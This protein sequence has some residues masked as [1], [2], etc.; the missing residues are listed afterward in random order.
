MVLFIKQLGIQFHLING[1][2]N[3]VVNANGPANHP[4]AAFPIIAV[5]GFLC[6]MDRKLESG[7]MLTGY[8]SNWRK[9][10]RC[11]ARKI[12][13]FMTFIFAIIHRIPLLQYCLSVVLLDKLFYQTSSIIASYT[14][15]GLWYCSMG[16]SNNTRLR[17]L[18]CLA[19]THPPY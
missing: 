5:S 9:H 2:C 13:L 8:L 3:E 19:L 14:G 15:W 7:G 10:Y 16:C 18:L 17:M 1:P 11:V 4:R 12:K 6:S